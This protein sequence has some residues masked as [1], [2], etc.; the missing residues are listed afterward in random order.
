MITY[1]DMAMETCL[2]S[3]K[4][5]VYAINGMTA[6]VGEITLNSKRIPNYLAWSLHRVL[7]L[8]P[9]E[10]TY[11]IDFQRIVRDF[12]FGSKGMYDEVISCIETLSE[13]GYFYQEYLEE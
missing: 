1:Q 11:D 6:E 13:A 7:L 4:N 2:P 12:V 5:E 9:R 8:L 3:C 10:Y